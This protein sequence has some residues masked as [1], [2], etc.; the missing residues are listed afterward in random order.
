MDG[1]GGMIGYDEAPLGRERFV[2]S[3]ESKLSNNSRMLLH[4]AL[5]VSH[6][7]PQLK[8]T[9]GLFIIM[10]QEILFTDIV[11]F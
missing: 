11:A 7:I 3:L 5:I 1:F 6:T 2:K 8:V 9:K 10:L 4:A